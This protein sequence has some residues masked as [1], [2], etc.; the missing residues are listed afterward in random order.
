MATGCCGCSEKKK[1]SK[2]MSG[3]RLKKYP[4]DDRS[5]TA[6]VYN[7]DVSGEGGKNE[8]KSGGSWEYIGT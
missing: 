5:R 3:W 1:A 6:Y 2:C 8:R 7:E 4:D